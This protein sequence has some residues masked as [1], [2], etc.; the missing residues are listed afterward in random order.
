MKRLK[1]THT[2]S[3]VLTM[4]SCSTKFKILDVLLDQNGLHQQKRNK[5]INPLATLSWTALAPWVFERG[6]KRLVTSFHA[7]S[8]LCIMKRTAIKAIIEH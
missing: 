3:K 7:S 1:K 4:V 5:N 6:G 8:M 2:N